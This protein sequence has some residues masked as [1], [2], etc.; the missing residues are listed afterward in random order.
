MP[1]SH[2]SE[3]LERRAREIVDSLG[4]E[5]RRSK[6]MCRCPAHEDRTPSLSVSLGRHA[7][8]LH[9]FAGCTNEAVIA[10][11]AR[12][13]VRARE[14]F[15][16]SGEPVLSRG[17]ASTETE[18][19]AYQQVIRTTCRGVDG[20]LAANTSGAAVTE[21]FYDSRG[22]LLEKRYYDSKR[23]AGRSLDR[24]AQEKLSL[25]A[26]GIEQSTTLLAA[27]GTQL[28][29]PR[30]RFLSV[31]VGQPNEFW[32]ARTREASL[33]RIEVARERIIGGLDFT[34]ALQQYG[35]EKVNLIHP[36]DLG[37]QDPKRFY[38]AARVAVESLAVGQYSE[39]V[40]LPFGFAI[41]QRTE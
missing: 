27:D 13:G 10:A 14:L 22:L 6:G 9:C 34:H 20:E 7:I 18:Y 21:W 15:D 12:H 1:R 26:L 4:G 28:H 37:Y 41:Y 11:L 17:C 16:G 31:E 5:W 19:N 32:P 30:F 3:R 8:L 35:D 40:E 38:S 24:L 2:R 29:L 36:G 25:D 39:I 23:L 33:A